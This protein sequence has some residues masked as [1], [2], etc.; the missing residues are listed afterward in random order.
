MPNESPVN[1][2]E[3]LVRGQVLFRP[4]V[5]LGNGEV[6]GYV[7]TLR[8]PPD[9]HLHAP[10]SLYAE[11]RKS[12]RLQELEGRYWQAAVERFSDLGLSGRLYLRLGFG[13]FLSHK[14]RSVQIGKSIRK[15]GRE[16]VVVE[17]RLGPDFQGWR[18]LHKAMARFGEQGYS[19]A[20]AGAPQVPQGISPAYFKLGRHH[21][22]DL[23][24]DPAKAGFVADL[25]EK[26]NALG[27]TVIAE[28]IG[29]RGEYLVLRELG[30]KLGQ[31]DFI[32]RWSANPSRS[33]SRDVEDILAL[34]GEPVKPSAACGNLIEPA[35][36][37]RLSDT[38]ERVFRALD[39]NPEL[40]V[41]AVVDDRGAPVG[42]IHRIAFI[43]RFARQYQRELYGRKSCA[44]L[45]DR[46]PLI[47]DRNISIHE[48][49]RL[50]SGDQRHVS[51]GFI[52]TEKGKYLGVGTSQ[53][54]IN[55]IAEM[56]IRAA[57]H[58]NPLTGL[59][60]NIPVEEC[61]DGLIASRQDFCVCHFDLDHFKPFNDVHGFSLG[62][63]MIRMTAKVIVS[64]C[65]PG[66]DFVGHIGGDD[67]IVV[68]RSED[69]ETRARD[70]LDRFGESRLKFFDAEVIAGGGYLAPNRRGEEE[71][72]PLVSLSIG[73]VQVAAG[74]RG[75]RLDIAAV[76]AE[77]KKMAKRLPGNA[78]FVN[79]RR[80][81]QAS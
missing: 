11:A 10:E 65:D 21:V 41:A 6:H 26:L 74:F 17:L 1:F 51:Q 79:Q 47:V 4:I 56:Q 31:G 34:R 58:A 68:F 52:F 15:A 38:N 23:D 44:E 20:L 75:S 81:V 45:M 14:I 35:P 28:G 80:L 43:D 24:R 54:L 3:L 49:G 13:I 2:Q 69:W 77:S 32:G 57:R 37:F 42:L 39:E 36:P 25:V 64:G 71:F 63:A 62:D 78:L 55:R 19:V 27:T 40:S 8:G 61:I 29:T 59:P 50:V 33:L 72:H 73:A 30:V 66:T 70:M 76:A 53:C 16:C 46:N 7:A 22:F 12:D 5:D 18:T 48:L 67:F 60:G 9:S